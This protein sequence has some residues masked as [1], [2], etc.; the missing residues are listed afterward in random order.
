MKKN[1]L[2]SLVLAAAAML[3]E[4]LTRGPSWLLLVYLLWV[5]VLVIEY[6]YLNGWASKRKERQRWVPFLAVA[7]VL[8]VGVVFQ[9]TIAVATLLSSK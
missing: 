4:Y 1:W 8:V 2:G 9:G 3:L 5:P 7:L 6:H